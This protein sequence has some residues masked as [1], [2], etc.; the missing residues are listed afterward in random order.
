MR[1]VEVA[2]VERSGIRIK[3]MDQ[4]EAIYPN[5]YLRY[6]CACTACVD[7][8]TRVRRV[9]A[10]Q[11]PSDIHPLR[12]APVGQYAI[13]ID[14]SDGHNTGIYS[15]DMLREICPCP[16]CSPDGRTQP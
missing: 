15:F 16:G 9:Q 14:W 5:A 13:R 11:I 8:W 6:H 7:E 2:R 3:W 10:D 12:I 4:H 1:P